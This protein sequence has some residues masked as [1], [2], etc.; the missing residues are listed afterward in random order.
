MPRS[1]GKKSEDPS[2]EAERLASM[3]WDEVYSWIMQF[4]PIGAEQLTE[5]T[6]N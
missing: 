6:K 4:M 2:K 1:S 5:A 3:Q